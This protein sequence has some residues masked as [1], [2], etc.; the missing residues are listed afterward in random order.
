MK[1]YD[2]HI[3]FTAAELQ[4]QME[5]MTPMQQ[6]RHT[7]FDTYLNK[8]RDSLKAVQKFCDT[9]EQ[10]KQLLKKYDIV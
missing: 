4:K 7:Y 10:Y 9:E 6:R 2:D 5:G 8:A 3:K 1:N